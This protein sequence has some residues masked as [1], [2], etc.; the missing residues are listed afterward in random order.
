[1]ELPDNTLNFAKKH[2]LMDEVVVPQGNQPLL[3]KKD[4]N[5]TQLVVERVHALD[6]KAYEVLFVGTGMGLG[7]LQVHGQKM[8]S[9]EDPMFSILT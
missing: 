1:M 5:F 7:D 9:V 3:V 2:P 8:L 6:G 4:A